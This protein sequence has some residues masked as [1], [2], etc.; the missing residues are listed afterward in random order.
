MVAF[1]EGS[2][3]TVHNVSCLQDVPQLQCH[4]HTG[5]DN[6]SHLV[7]SDG[8][9]DRRAANM[10]TAMVAL[11][12]LILPLTVALNLTVVVTVLLN[13]KL[14]TVVNVL[15]V[16]LGINNLVWTAF[17]VVV[18]QQAKQLE[19][20]QCAMRAFLFIN[21]RSINFT[22]IVTITVLRY[23]IVVRNHSYPAGRRNVLAVVSIAVLPSL[24]KW[25]IRRS[26]EVTS[27]SPVVAKNPD[28]F[29]LVIKFEHTIDF[30]T[31]LIAVVEYGGGL[32]ILGFCYTRILVTTARSRRRVEA[33]EIARRKMEQENVA[34][35]SQQPPVCNQQTM[36]VS[37]LRQSRSFRFHGDTHPSSSNVEPSVSAGPPPH[38]PGPTSQRS[39]ST[40]GS[41]KQGTL[42]KDMKCAIS[43]SIST[44][45]TSDGSSARQRDSFSTMLDVPVSQVHSKMNT[46]LVVVQSLNG[47]TSAGGTSTD[48]IPP[49]TARAQQQ[50]AGAASDSLT[51]QPMN[52]LNDSAGGSRTSS[53]SARDF[54]SPHPI[55]R[56]PQPFSARV[57]IVATLSM[58]A[59]IVILFLVIFPYTLGVGLVNSRSV[60]VITAEMR[61]V[62]LTIVLVSSGMGAVLSPIALVL[63]SADFRK[64]FRSLCD[65]A[66]RR[67]RLTVRR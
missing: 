18:V 17:P 27:C 43:S 50:P 44:S 33:P 40:R 14:H 21:T 47:E 46:T 52:L 51:L 28:G 60:C 62:M 1:A 2:S 63:F 36:T 4:R 37:V 34:N 42:F 15:V 41:E 48:Q 53:A 13:R 39:T 11:N 20:L 58:T 31:G 7:C 38:G 8:A 49:F 55:N 10:Y 65:R 24:I 57:D 66:R 45:Q 19:P 61:L 9:G 54:T 30:L 12:G 26:H 35:V 5:P 64:G 29:L 3:G 6:T 22:V 67:L 32:C 23:L 25:F 59:F 16:V 56:L